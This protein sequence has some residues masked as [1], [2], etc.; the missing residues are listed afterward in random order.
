MSLTTSAPRDIAGQWEA[1]RNEIV[2]LYLVE[3]K[4]LSFV[5]KYM[6]EKY[7]FIAS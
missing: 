3:D 6:E 7:G 5:K 1:H 2:E 4:P